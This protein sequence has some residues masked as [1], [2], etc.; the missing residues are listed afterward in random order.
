MAYIV[1]SIVGTGVTYGALSFLKR[2]VSE[3]SL[4]ILGNNWVNLISHAPLPLLLQV[5]VFFTVLPL[6]F[7]D[8]P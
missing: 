1:C 8:Q 5:E 4:M 6:C 7:G 3:I 2:L